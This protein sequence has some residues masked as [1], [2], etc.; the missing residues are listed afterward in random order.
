ME[1]E[2]DRPTDRERGKSLSTHKAVF[3]SLVCAMKIQTK[4]TTMMM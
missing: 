2:T 3:N 4:T 1:R